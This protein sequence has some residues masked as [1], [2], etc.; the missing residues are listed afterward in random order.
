MIFPSNVHFLCLFVDPFSKSVVVLVTLDRPTAVACLCASA[1]ILF[2]DGRA[3]RA[4]NVG[5]YHAYQKV[6]CSSRHESQSRL[7][8]FL[9]PALLSGGT[10][11][12]KQSSRNPDMV[13]YTCR[14]TPDSE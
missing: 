3:P 12:R 9:R 1:M 7:P 2:S 8:P 14:L 5:W 13:R 6:Y 4:L 10:C 11:L